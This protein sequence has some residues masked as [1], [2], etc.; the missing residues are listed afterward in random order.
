VL[1]AFIKQINSISQLF[2]ALVWGRGRLGPEELQHD[3]GQK[4][5]KKTKSEIT[6]FLGSKKRLE[7]ERGMADVAACFVL[8]IVALPCI[9]DCRRMFFSWGYVSVVCV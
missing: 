8:S 3:A 5:G 1:F 2:Y 4:S 6:G 7:H 9:R